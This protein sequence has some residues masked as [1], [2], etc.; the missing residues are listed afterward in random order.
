MRK[1]GELVDL[2]KRVLDIDI[3]SPVFNSMLNDLDEEIQRVVKNV[4]EGKFASGEISLKLDL[5]IRDAFKEIPKEDIYGN[6][7]NEKYEYK[8]PSFEHKITST[9]KKEYKSKGCYEENKEVVW[10][11]IE[12]KFVV[13]PLMDP[14]LRFKESELE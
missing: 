3:E 7:I 9:L 13:Q 14:Q 5:K 2:S 1:I 11:E 12:G 4:Y 10:N 8:K 6:M